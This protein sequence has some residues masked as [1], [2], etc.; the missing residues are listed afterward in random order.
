MI[1]KRA[2]KNA[3][4]EFLIKVRGLHSPTS[5]QKLI[6]T[7]LLKSLHYKYKKLTLKLFQLKEDYYIE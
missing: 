2:V 7:T 1:K 3:L 4:F 6:I 5:F